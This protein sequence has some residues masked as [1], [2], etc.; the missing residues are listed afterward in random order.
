MTISLE[1]D[2]RFLMQQVLECA[3]A[4]GNL[5]EEE[6]EVAKRYSKLIE[7]EIYKERYERRK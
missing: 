2:D 7:D 1:N 4:S 3:I 6:L 5:N